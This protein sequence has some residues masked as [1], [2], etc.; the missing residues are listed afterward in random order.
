[1]RDP[2][3]LPVAALAGG[4]L[5]A[6]LSSFTSL[7]I[8]LGVTGGV[9]LAVLCLWR[10]ARV[11]GGFAS[12]LGLFCAGVWVAQVH[13]PPPAP[14]LDAADGEVALLGGCVVEPSALSEG[15]E[16]FVLELEPGARVQV[17][18][19]QR[20]GETLPAL[21]YGENIE[22]DAKVRKPHNYGNPGAFDYQRY[23]AR[24]DVYWTASAASSAVKRL[25]GSCGSRFQA[26]M[27]SLRTAALRR[28][29]DLYPGDSYATG[30][31]QAILIGQ[32]FQLRRIWTEN[33][34]NTGTFH[35]LVI[36]GTHVAVLAGFFLFLLRLCFVGEEAAFA[37]VVLAAW[38]YAVVTGWQAP[39]VR[40]A[41][42]MTLFLIGRY[43]YRERRVLNLLAAVAMGYLLVDP[44][45]LFEPSFQLTFL[46]V[47]FI[48]AFAQPLIEATSGPLARA[49]D[50]LDDRDHDLRL[51]PRAAQFRVE[52]RLLAETLRLAA[53]LPRGVANALVTAP[54]RILFF[55]YEVV[56]VSAMV[57]MGLAL[58]MVVYFHRIGISGLSANALIVPLMGAVVP[59]GFIA[60]F[61]GFH[62]VGQCAGVILALSRIIV[63][64][65]A[66]VEPNWHIPAPPV[67]LAVLVSAS[68]IATA[69]AKGRW[70]IPA[71]A[72]VAVSLGLLIW[73]PFRPQIRPGNL[74]LTA[75]DVGQGDSLLVAFP[76]G[77]TMVVDGG[78][79]PSFAGMT[80]RTQLDIGEDVVAPYLWTRSLRHV[81]VLAMS[82]AHDDHMGGL[83]AL[84]RD[85]QPRELW[86]GAAP[87]S[88]AWRS[89]RRQAEDAGV[90][91]IAWRGP[92]QMA[93]GG[94]QIEVLAPPQDYQPADDAKNN[95]SLVMRVRYGRHTFMLTGDVERQ[96]EGQLFD[97]A[98]ALRCDVLKVA[99]HGSRT[100][101][102][103]QFLNAVQPTFAI[104]S[105]AGANNYGLPHPTVIER[106]REHH[107]MILR[108]D[109]DGLVTVR[110]DGRHLSIDTQRWS[111]S[112]GMGLLSAF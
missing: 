48:G 86:I 99:H 70:R 14:R 43:F 106:L 82:H 18:L 71:A 112:S 100:S 85:F 8:A 51:P 24:Q 4:I 28:I 84:L 21:G 62:W 42:G 55:V 33:Y 6:R 36:S 77:Q 65:H 40:S 90:R 7:D 57:Q 29:E 19:Y 49:L 32:S 12:L 15:R 26:W 91:V 5:A 108:T 56:A 34:R 109:Q 83:P 16:R 53:H 10:Q 95:D 64:W 13:T 37:I 96:I 101:T 98:P 74:E 88:P 79:I 75:I 94:A 97:S 89:L 107:A 93:F 110:S 30:M 25:P 39:C 81:D 105:V 61:T 54:S 92:R 50:D 22:V 23:L 59:V 72:T 45:Q 9:L 17:T 87:D 1:M 66:G 67:W 2:L 68:L 38:L 103:E 111:A 35:A 47:A 102:T 73:H 41:A 46:A 27:M 78:G 3:L 11:T 58:P 60:I 76:N 44:D 69:A 31:M 20:P 104:I 80:P 52:L 63:D